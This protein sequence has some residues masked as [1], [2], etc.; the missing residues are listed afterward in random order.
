MVRRS[1]RMDRSGDAEDSGI[2]IFFEAMT[3]ETIAGTSVV[4]LSAITK[5]SRCSRRYKVDARELWGIEQCC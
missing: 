2:G 5:A 4:Y 1:P 3:W